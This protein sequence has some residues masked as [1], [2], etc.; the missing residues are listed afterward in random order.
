[1]RYLTLKAIAVS[2]AAPQ[3]RREK[4]AIALDDT[5]CTLLSVNFFFP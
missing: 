2:L 4:S 3:E 1:M 5:I